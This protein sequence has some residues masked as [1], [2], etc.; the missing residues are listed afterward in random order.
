MFSSR[1]HNKF[2]DSQMVLGDLLHTALVDEDSLKNR[3][4]LSSGNVHP[5]KGRQTLKK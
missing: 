4:S 5:G 1:R 2:I 3:L